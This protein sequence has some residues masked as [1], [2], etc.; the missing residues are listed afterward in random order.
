VPPTEQFEFSQNLHMVGLHDL[1]VTLHTS[2]PHRR[3]ILVLS[4]N[5]VL[6]SV[7]VL[8]PELVLELN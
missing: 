4:S 5:S 3:V 8:V 1:E 6:N 7:L 2:H